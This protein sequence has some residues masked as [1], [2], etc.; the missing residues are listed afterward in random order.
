VRKKPFEIFENDKLS[1]KIAKITTLIIT[2][3]IALAFVS[4]VIFPEEGE[5]LPTP[6]E[7]LELMFF[8]TGVL[9]GM[10]LAWKWR[11]TGPLITI[12]SLA[13]FYA[14]EYHAKQRFPRG[15]TPFLI[16]VPA[17]IFLIDYFVSKNTG[18]RV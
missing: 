9:A 1:I 6:Y 11:L 3:L 12:G 4:N 13:I 2:A 15:L 16:I 17:F 14:L 10:L 7:F 5:S 8:P 18:S